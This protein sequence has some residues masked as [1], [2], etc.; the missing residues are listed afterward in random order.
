MKFKKIGIVL[1]LALTVLAFSLAALTGCKGK[2]AETPAAIE[3]IEKNA[4]TQ[5]NKYA[6]T[7]V[8]LRALIEDLNQQKEDLL[9]ELSFNKQALKIIQKQYETTDRFIDADSRWIEKYFTDSLRTDDTTQYGAEG[10]NAP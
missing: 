2:P 10:S 3:K 5:Q 9:Q 1:I 4:E 6:D 8:S 7:L